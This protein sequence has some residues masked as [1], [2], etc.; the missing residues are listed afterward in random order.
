M[1]GLR[2]M[3]Q[4]IENKKHCFASPFL[5]AAFTAIMK[6]LGVRV[7]VILNPC[8]HLSY[9]QGVEQVY[10][11]QTRREMFIQTLDYRAPEVFHMVPIVGA[12]IDMWSM[13]ITLCVLLEHPFTSGFGRRAGEL[14]KAWAKQLGRSSVKAVKGCPKPWPTN[15]KRDIGV[16]GLDLLEKLLDF[17]PDTRLSASTA[18]DH[19]FFN[20]DSFSMMG[21]PVSADVVPED[22]GIVELRPCQPGDVVEFS[23]ERHAW[24]I[25]AGQMAPDVLA[26]YK[27]SRALTKGTDENKI[28]AECFSKH[29]DRKDQSE[30]Q[31][32]KDGEDVKLVI[33]GALRKG[34]GSAFFNKSTANP[35]P[36][37]KSSAY[38]EAFKTVNKASLLAVEAS[39]VKPVRYLTY[40]QKNLKNGRHFLKTPLDRWFLPTNQLNFTK[41]IK[42]DASHLVENKHFDGSTSVFHMGLGVGGRR[43]LVCNQT[44]SAPQ[45]LLKNIP[46]TVYLGQL[47]GAEHQVFHQPCPD[48]ELVDATGFGPA[49]CTLMCRTALFPHG[50]SRLMNGNVHT[51][52]LK[53]V[54]VTAF[55]EGLRNNAFRLPSLSECIEAEERLHLTLPTNTRK[56]QKVSTVMDKTMTKSRV[57]RTALVKRAKKVTRCLDRKKVAAAK[58]ETADASVHAASSTGAAAGSTSELG[59]EPHGVFAD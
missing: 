1:H 16:G 41:G 47:T 17:D 59:D 15:F 37:N 10:V 7:C 45:V 36:C 29:K 12:A 24:N 33:T 50:M 4:Y 43:N 23:G 46:G 9:S 28:V 38:V 22:T 31:A 27:S 35:C 49:S 11:L 30:V 55:R 52:E 19:Q 48:D 57:R 58:L 21:Y 3:Y 5:K 44:G 13:G 40:K 53:A 2:P 42:R 32:T 54:F 51:P 8:F 56:C 18:L 14:P 39:V 6:K 26:W 25:R 20:P 34:I